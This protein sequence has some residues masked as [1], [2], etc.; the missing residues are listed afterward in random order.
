MALAGRFSFSVCAEESVEVV[1]NVNIARETIK[2]NLSSF[3]NL[4]NTPPPSY[5][6]KAGLHFIRAL[7]RAARFLTRVFGKVN[8]SKRILKKSQFILYF[9]LDTRRSTAFFQK[10]KQ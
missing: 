3:P 5:F 7:Q 6:L 2:T 8:A 10:F 9:Q 4:I 1:I